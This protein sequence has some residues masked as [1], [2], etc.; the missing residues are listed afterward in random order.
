MEPEVEKAEKAVKADRRAG[1]Q[2]G[3][4][5]KGVNVV[6]FRSPGFRFQENRGRQS[7]KLGFA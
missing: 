3:R 1:R 4:P 7:L 6:Q 2:A 5:V